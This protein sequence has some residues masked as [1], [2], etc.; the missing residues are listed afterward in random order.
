MGIIKAATGMVGGALADSWLEVIEPNDLGQDTLLTNGIAVRRDDKRGSNKKGTADFLT[1]GSVIHVPVNTMML[2]VDGGKVIDYSAEEGYYTVKNDSAPSMFAGNLKGSIDEAFKRFKFGGVTPQ[3][4][5]V[6]FINLAEVKGIKFGTPSPLQ[7]FDNFYN[8][9]LFVRA[10]GNYSIKISDPILFYANA[11]PRNLN[12]VTIDDINAQFLSEFIM[13]LTA[14][15]NQLSTQGMRISYLPSK[16]TELSQ[17]MSTTLDESWKSLRGI[18]VVSV[19]VESIS[20]TQD[21]QELINMRNKGA[22]LGDPSIREGFVQGSI[23]EGLK[24]AGSNA[25]GAGNAF[26][27]MGMGMN[28]GSGAFFQNNAQ[29]NK[30]NEQSAKAE[31]A[32]QQKIEMACA[33]CGAIVNL[34]AGIPKFCANCGQP[35]VAK[36]LG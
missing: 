23:A 32:E 18:E 25:A 36:P 19:A 16:S 15:I 29:N 21:S 22:M 5:Q 30:P 11:V 35:F 27:G 3:K 20:Y 4:Q 14:S 9:E 8:A 24:D 33:N 26:F 10:F 6:F 13:A 7:Y 1:D 12:R 28:A 17:F 34:A 31:P 2:L